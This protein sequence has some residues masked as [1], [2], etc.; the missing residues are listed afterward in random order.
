M[1]GCDK[2]AVDEPCSSEILDECLVLPL[3]AVPSDVWSHVW[4][5]KYRLFTKLNAQIETNLR[6]EFIKLN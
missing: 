3:V 2:K 6:D 1:D 4:S 5:I